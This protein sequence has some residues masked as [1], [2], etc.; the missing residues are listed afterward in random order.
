MT[1]GSASPSEMCWA[2]WRS[3]SAELTGASGGGR[4]SRCSVRSSACRLERVEVRAADDGAPEAFVDGIPTDLSLSL[5]H[6]DGVAV[7]AVAPLPTRVGIDLETLEPRSDAFVREWLSGEEQA[8]L[9]TAGEARDV[10]VL[11]CW[12]GKE[13]SAKV[14][15]EGL[16]LDVR[17][18]VVAADPSTT[19][20]APLE[21]TWRAERVSHRG[22]WRRDRV[23]V[24]A[25][26]T[27]P[28]TTHPPV[29]AALAT[30]AAR[31]TA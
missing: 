4:R 12:T 28:P 13:A 19:H 18:A 16:R 3:P 23:G 5:S 2:G 10:G 31:G 25:I 22:W 8:A 20:W 21:V 24:L 14:M 30:L 26:V 27:D 6:R 11:C 29:V 15:R 1:N 7:A 17:H 9:P